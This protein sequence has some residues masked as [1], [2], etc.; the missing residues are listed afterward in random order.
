VPIR[1][2]LQFIESNRQ[3]L[4]SI[5]ILIA[6]LFLLIFA[7]L[8]EP[9]L[10]KIMNITTFLAWHNLFEISMVIAYFAIFLVTYY[11]YEQTHR[12]RTILIGSMLLAAGIL[13]ALHMLSYKGMPTFFIENTSS[14]RATT[15]WILSKLFFSLAFLV[16][17]NI[18][19]TIKCTISKIY[20]FLVPLLIS[21]IIFITV[22]WY[23]AFLPAMFVEGYGLTPI[24]IHLEYLVMLM[25]LI[26][27]IVY[28]RNSYK[29][30]DN[31]LRI[32]SCALI[33]GMF[34]EFAFTEYVNVYDINNYIGHLLGV[35]SLFMAFRMTFA[36]NVLA[37][38]I[39]LTAA[40]EALSRHAENQERTIEQRT[41]QM[42]L[43][44]NKL[45]EDL[46]VAR[47]IQKSLLPVF[48]P[49]TEEISF[50]AVYLPT[51]RL[52]GD[53]Y[54]VF[55]LDE[56]HIGF[57][58]CDVSGHGV[59]AAMLTVFLKQ[60]VDNI[61][62]T[63]RF[64]GTLSS[65]SVLLRQVYDAFNHSKFKDDVYIVLI[66]CIYDRDEKKLTCSSAG[67]NVMPLLESYA[68]N[69][70]K[71]EMKGF[72]ICKLSD[73]CTAE[74]ND[75]D[76]RVQN[77]DRLYLYTD[78]LSEARNSEGAVYTE[79]RLMKLLAEN[80][81]RKLFELSSL[82]MDDLIDFSDGKKMEDDVTLLAVEFRE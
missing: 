77:G 65:P 75:Y 7:R 18:S 57:Y 53:F 60:C 61:V 14:N 20:F 72:P 13:E 76:V 24:K 36:R 82:I 68:G 17:G 6:S 66:Y 52:S 40:Q 21:L 31:L 47:G 35:C 51:D 37:P 64:K 71:V 42:K 70:S 79:S 69:I 23:P 58:V 55:N 50:N 73:V 30:H 19:D 49:D 5:L 15:F 27:A 46:E 34:S 3:L 29:Y 11:A 45:L 59:P 12:L 26:A 16:G 39:A 8:L 9:V 32:I 54:D 38:Y 10:E 48:L 56:Q 74:F 22:T 81:G 44:N 41:G 33:L 4:P 80:R 63:D 2:V 67:M 43:M 25:L 1:R 78:G 62:E 28:F